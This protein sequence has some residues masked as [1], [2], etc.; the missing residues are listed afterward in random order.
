MSVLALDLDG[1][2]YD[3]ITPYANMLAQEHGQDLLP[4]GWRTNI[5]L[6]APVWDWEIHYGYPKEVIRNVWKRITAKNSHFWRDL[7]LRNGATEALK[8]L[9]TLSRQDKQVV[10][11][12]NRAGHNVK[13]QTEVA[14]YRAGINYPTILIAADKVPVLR[15]IGAEFFI[16]DKGSTLNDCVRSALS[17][18]PMWKIRLFLLDAP[19]NREGRMGGYTVV[20][21]VQEAL[22][23]A[24]L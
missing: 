7:P 10:F 2:F 1:V 12:T 21:T 3:F 8:R 5:E 22:E 13:Y 17:Q 6:H 9:N 24:G 19:Y 23:C 16:D 20:N 15:S 11:L 4:E 14:L 18:G